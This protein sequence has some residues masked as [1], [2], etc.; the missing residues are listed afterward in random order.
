MDP[1]RLQS[2][3]RAFGNGLS[4]RALVG[5]ALGSGG[6]ALAAAGLAQATD[7]PTTAVDEGE[8]QLREFVLTAS[9]FAWE[10]MP[11]TSVHAWGYNGQ[12]PGPELRVREGN[13]VRVT[14]RN[15][16]PVPTTIH[17]H[18]IDVPPAM[19]GPAGLNQAPVEP[20]Q[21]FV[22]EF[23]AKPAGSRWYH[24]HADPA[25]QIPLGLYGPFII[26]PRQPAKTYDREY[27]LMLA[28]WD[29]ELTPAVAAGLAE[30]GPR[31]RLLRGGELG[32]DLFLIN[33]RM[34]SA[35]SPIRVAEGEVI[36]LRLM[37]AGH[38]AHPF[39]T[40]GH[41]FKIVATDGNPVPEV[42]QLTKDTVLVGPAER[43]DLELVGNNPGV[44][45]VH[46]HIEHHMANGMMTVIAYDGHQ[47]SGPV[48]DVFALDELGPAGGENH[49]E[50]GETQAASAPNPAS[51]EPLAAPQATEGDVI[52]IA[53]VDDRFDP[54]NLTI[55][56]GTTVV[57]VNKGHDW[58]SVAAFDGTFESSRVGPGERFAA[59]IDR[60]GVY[61]YLCKHHGLQGMIGMLTVT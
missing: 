3:T 26:E 31:D 32:S 53:M 12:V 6:T 49:T 1:R 9:E 44:W 33:G 7:D 47:P 20:G 27:T 46:C 39:H 11:G 13:L 45:M 15:A 42:A 18:G 19:D 58:H 48:A 54:N 22:Y 59:Q 40:H 5:G 24:S 30:R 17:W 61:Q 23:V 43:Y 56:P 2:L 52:E 50:H 55:P 14:L 10:L 34:H 28:E 60:P 8:P 38:L 37:H 29:D 21:E 16:L 57:W 41:S 51:V 25:L 4:R 36:L 35:I